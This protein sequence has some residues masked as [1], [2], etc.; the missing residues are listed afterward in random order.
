M[1]YEDIEQAIKGE[2]FSMSTVKNI[3]KEAGIESAKGKGSM[4]GKW[5]WRLAEAV[6]LSIQRALAEVN[7]KNAAA[8]KPDLNAVNLTRRIDH[9]GAGFDANAGAGDPIR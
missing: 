4:T 3:K 1:L 5:V 6:A 7:R 8:G 2:P 9:Y